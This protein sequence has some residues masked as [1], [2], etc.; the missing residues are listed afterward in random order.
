MLILIFGRY[1]EHVMKIIGN[2]DQFD[3]ERKT[4][5]ESEVRND[6]RAGTI[7]EH[8]QGE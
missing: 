8:G 5:R 3:R 7:D 2:G 4:E 1:R 6:V